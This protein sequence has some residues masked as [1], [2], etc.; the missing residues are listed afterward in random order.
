MGVIK[1]F[2]DGSHNTHLYYK[3]HGGTMMIMGCGAI[4]SYSWIIKVK[5]RSSTETELVSVDA[6]MPD[7]L[8]SL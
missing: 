3:G 6:Y 8:W 2:V 1:W 4:S 7:V 5:T